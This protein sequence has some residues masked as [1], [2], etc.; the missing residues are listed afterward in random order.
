MMAKGKKI[1]ARAVATAFYGYFRPGEIRG[2]LKADHVMPSGGATRALNHFALVVSLSERLE[3]SKTQTFDDT[4]ILDTPG[5]LGRLLQLSC[6]DV[7]PIEKLFPI[8]VA[9]MLVDWNEAL[10]ELRIPKQQLVWYQLRHGGAS[11]DLLERRRSVPEIQ[12]RGRW[13]RPESMRRYAKSGQIQKVL[14]ALPKDV[15]R[16]T[17]WAAEEFREIMIGNVTAR[18]PVQSAQPESDEMASQRA[19]RMEFE[20]QGGVAKCTGASGRRRASEGNGR[21]AGARLRAPGQTDWAHV[22]TLSGIDGRHRS[23]GKGGGG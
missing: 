5:F 6:M 16:F 10:A 3:A 19:D 8:T 13:M 15:R 4:V 18:L 17:R 20:N 1:T 14:N 9:E 2:F 11:A 12:A 22:Q 21:R 23:S 7:T